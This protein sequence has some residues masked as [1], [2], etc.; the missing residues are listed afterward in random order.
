[1]FKVGPSSN[2]NSKFK[3]LCHKVSFTRKNLKNEGCIHRALFGLSA[4]Q[5]IRKFLEASFTALL[6]IPENLV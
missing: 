2:S 1:M 3:H 5:C 4:A 6:S